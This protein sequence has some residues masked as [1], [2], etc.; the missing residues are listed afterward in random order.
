MKHL[1]I[2]CKGRSRPD[3]AVHGL[4]ANGGFRIGNRSSNRPQSNG[5][6]ERLHR[7][8]L[9][10]HFR[11]MGH[12]KWYETIEEMQIDLDPYIARP[13]GRLCPASVLPSWSCLVGVETWN[14][15]SSN[16]SLFS[17]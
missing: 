7:T 13:S 11:V 14:F 4:A 17:E 9:D 8:L 15:R 6:V 3:A 12:K 16:L 5:Y 10:E 1:S 2:R